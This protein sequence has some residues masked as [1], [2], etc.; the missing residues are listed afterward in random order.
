[1]MCP[2]FIWLN[3]LQWMITLNYVYPLN[4]AKIYRSFCQAFLKRTHFG[5]ITK[6]RMITPSYVYPLNKAKIQRSFCQAF[7][8]KRGSHSSRNIRLI[9]NIFSGMRCHAGSSGPIQVRTTVPHSPASRYF[10]TTSSTSSQ[11]IPECSSHKSS[12]ELI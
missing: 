9:F 4:K 2:I 10:F 5:I 8:E 7:L 11:K 3:A 6:P 1:M 12:F